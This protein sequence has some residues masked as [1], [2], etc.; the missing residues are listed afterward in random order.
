MALCDVVPSGERKP[1]ASTDSPVERGLSL[2]QVLLK[3]SARTVFK[4]LRYKR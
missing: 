4:N 2:V 1:R 3:V